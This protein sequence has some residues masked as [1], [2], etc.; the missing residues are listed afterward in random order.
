M[1]MVENHLNVLKPGSLLCG[2]C[3]TGEHR[4]V[5]KFFPGLSPVEMYAAH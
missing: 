3:S 2:F 4:I 1:L 5:S